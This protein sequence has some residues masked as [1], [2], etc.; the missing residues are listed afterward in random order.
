MKYFLY[1]IWGTCL[2]INLT[3]QNWSAAVANIMVL[4]L[5]IEKFESSNDKN[6]G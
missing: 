5:L 1:I 4:F 2:A 3:I 6:E